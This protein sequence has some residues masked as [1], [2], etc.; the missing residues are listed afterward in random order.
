MELSSLFGSLN[1]AWMNDALIWVV[2]AVAGSIGLVALV[3]ALDMFLDAE[4]H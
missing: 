4:M 3:N 2:A 1:G